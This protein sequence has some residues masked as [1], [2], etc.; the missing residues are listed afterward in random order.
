MGNEGPQA[1]VFNVSLVPLYLLQSTDVSVSPV[2][3]A[4]GV[5]RGVASLRPTSFINGTKSSSYTPP[6]HKC[7]SPH[8]V[9]GNASVPGYGKAKETH[10][11][12]SRVHS[13]GS[14]EGQAKPRALRPD[15]LQ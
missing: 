11:Q 2:C 1:H 7:V 14:E 3:I 15:S 10:F 6:C 9:S 5:K 8:C 4:E 13:G 12:A